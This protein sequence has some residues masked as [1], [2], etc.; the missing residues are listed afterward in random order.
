MLCGDA[1]CGVAGWLSRSLNSQSSVEQ[2][3]VEA[4]VQDVLSHQHHRGSD[5]RGLWASDNGQVVFGHN[6]LAIVELSEAG[7][8]PMVDAQND[9]V[10]TY[11]G[12]I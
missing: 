9:W 5:A 6:R 4:L 11:H 1:M 8:Q 2:R 7:A 3:T 12:E 10:I